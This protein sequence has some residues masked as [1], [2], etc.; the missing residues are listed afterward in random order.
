MAC[1][2]GVAFSKDTKEVYVSD[3]WKHCVHVFTSVGEYTRC[4]A[5]LKLR[6]PDGICMGPNGELVVCD[7]GNDR[8]VVVDPVTGDKIKVIGAQNGITQLNFPT[9]V[10]V[11]GQDIIVADSGNNR[12]SLT[13][14]DSYDV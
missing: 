12:V 1:P 6:C 14:C 9:S 10:A 5:N 11:Y 13:V 4:L 2:A 7:T 8:V 3:K